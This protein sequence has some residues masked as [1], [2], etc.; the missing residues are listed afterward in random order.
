MEFPKLPTKSIIKLVG[1][2]VVITAVGSLMVYPAYRSLGEKDLEAEKI[3]GNIEAQEILTPLFK[4]MLKKA[5]LKDTGKLTIPTKKPWP[6]EGVSNL[7][8][9][10]EKMGRTHGLDVEV[11]LPDAAALLRETLHLKIDII[12]RGGFVQFQPFLLAIYKAPYLEHVERIQIFAGDGME[13]MRLKL[14]INQK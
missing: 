13:E 9:L 11:R 7:L 6:R 12:A 1:C 5:R 10:F 2:L 3:Q 14:W 8:A 4:E